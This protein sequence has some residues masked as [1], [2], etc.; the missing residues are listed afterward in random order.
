MKALI[1]T[2][3]SGFVFVGCSLIVSDYVPSADIRRSSVPTH[4]V[5]VFYDRSEVPF[6]FKEIGR[7]YLKNINYWADRD[8]AGQINK[9]KE[10]AAACGADG[11]IIVESKRQ[12]SSFSVY[13]NSANGNSG[14]VYQYSGIAIIRE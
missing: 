12:E 1:T 11:V 7:V 13:N 8:P 5:Q 6:K 10:D 2:L 14:E 9:I 3:I 4:Y